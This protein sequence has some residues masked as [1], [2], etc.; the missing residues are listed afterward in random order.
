MQEKHL[1]VFFFK[2]FYI[3]EFFDSQKGAITL[4]KLS[5]LELN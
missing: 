3:F 5:L 4:R 1:K 2:K